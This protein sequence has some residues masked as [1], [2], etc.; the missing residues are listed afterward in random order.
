[1]LV[2][3]CGV[4]SGKQG[5]EKPSKEQGFWIKIQEYSGLKK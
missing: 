4:G 1:M 5:Q 2:G 3:E